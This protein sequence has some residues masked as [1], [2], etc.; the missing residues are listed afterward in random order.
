MGISKIVTNTVKAA[1]KT[2]NAPA[3]ATKKV[4]SVM[5]NAFEKAMPELQLAENSAYHSFSPETKEIVRKI[6]DFYWQNAKK[7]NN[8]TV[9]SNEDSWIKPLVQYGDNEKE[10]ATILKNIKNF[11]LYV[12]V[13]SRINKDLTKI[14]PS[15]DAPSVKTKLTLMAL[16]NKNSFKALTKSKGM[17]E[18][19]EGRLNISYLKD[20]KSTDKIDEDFFYKMFDNI[21]KQTN[22][23]LVNSGLDVDAIN[24]YL[25]ISDKKICKDPNF[26][27]EFVSDL[28][29][30]ED[31][32]LANKILK[33]W[34]FDSDFLKFADKNYRK[35]ISYAAL[36]PEITETALKINKATAFSVVDTIE[37]MKRGFSWNVSDDLFNTYLKFEKANPN[38]C[39]PLTINNINMFLGT[40]KLMEKG[41][42]ENFVKSILANPNLTKEI[43]AY[44]FEQIFSLAN[45]KNIDLLKSCV[46]KGKFTQKDWLAFQLKGRYD[47]TDTTISQ[48]YKETYEPLNNALKD[49]N[50]SYMIDS[51]ID[52]R[53]NNPKQYQKLVDSKILDLVKEKKINPRILANTNKDFTPEVY[54]DVQKLLNGESLIKKFDSTKDILHKTTAGDVVSVKGKMYINNDG[55]LEP[56]NMTEEKFNELFPLVDRFS[57]KQG[58]DDCYFISVLNSLYQNPKT[59]GNY[60]KMFEQKGDDILVTIPAYKNYLGTVKFP[61][62]EIETSWQNADAAKNVQM[63]ERTYA[64]TAVRTSKETPIGQNP[65]T[66]EDLNYLQNRIELGHTKNVFRELY[67][68]ATQNPQKVITDKA[69][70]TSALENYAQNPRYI[71]THS[72][73]PEG[74]QIGHAISIKSYDPKTQTVTLTDPEEAGV[75]RTQSLKDFLSTA[76]GII[77]SRVG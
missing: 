76:W 37:N 53:L 58:K 12:D 63:L 66:T 6:R 9:F 13:R 75:Q 47:V 14:I 22:K 28:E 24:K 70:I 27:N 68:S 39:Y 2:A 69:Q 19:K 30:I 65:I 5:E 77:V 59:R 3:Q 44:K 74:R 40:H 36:E 7:N 34:N 72:Y 51:V 18:I 42:N 29:K 46:E 67:P 33:K 32:E 54:S 26:V 52:T 64:R 25:K 4:A 57:T 43:G 73:L 10:V 15:N 56:W 1:V 20:I 55:K 62:G 11:N 21:E 41:V 38:H 31:P 71:I 48:I 35:V 61:K 8:P 17:K 49:T 16:F 60:Y 23:R 45:E 50:Y